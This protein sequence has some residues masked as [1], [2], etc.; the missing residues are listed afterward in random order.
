[1]S[2]RHRQQHLDA[3]HMHPVPHG[4]PQ[5]HRHPG[6]YYVVRSLLSTHARHMP[7]TGRRRPIS[8][9]LFKA[10]SRSSAPPPR[11]RLLHLGS[12]CTDLSHPLI[13]LRVVGQRQASARFSPTASFYAS[14]RVLSFSREQQNP[15]SKSLDRR[16][17]EMPLTDR[18]RIAAVSDMPSRRVTQITFHA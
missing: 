12:C 11:S 3:E 6:L 5:L 7:P 4:E 9:Y 18:V 13:P 16:M 10:E 1:M 14:P 2:H 17:S 8:E 15:C